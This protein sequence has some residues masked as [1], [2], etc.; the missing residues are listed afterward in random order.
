VSAAGPPLR[1]PLSARPCSFEQL[2]V[3]ARANKN[4]CS[5]SEFVEQNPVW[6][7]MAI[8][9]SRPIPAERMR[10][11]AGWQWLLTEQKA[12]NILQLV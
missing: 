1:P 7:D 6:L 12:D 4:Q 8:P 2:C 5:A 9:M 10:V 11:A 3:A